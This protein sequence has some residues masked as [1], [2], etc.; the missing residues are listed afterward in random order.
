VPHTVVERTRTSTWPAAGDGRGTSARTEKQSGAD[1]TTADM[2]SAIGQDEDLERA[3]DALG[4]R[5]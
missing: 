4:E 3:V 2:Q 1:N 5:V